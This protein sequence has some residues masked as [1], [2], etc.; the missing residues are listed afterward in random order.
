MYIHMCMCIYIYICVYI[1]IY[2]HIHMYIYIYIERYVYIYIYDTYIYEFVIS[3]L[4]HT[5]RL[6]SEKGRNPPRQRG[7]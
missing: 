1:Y 6:E 3:A 7:V 4:A 2:K 5:K